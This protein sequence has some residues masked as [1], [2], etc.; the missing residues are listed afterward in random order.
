MVKNSYGSLRGSRVLSRKSSSLEN[1]QTA[2]DLQC[3]TQQ[4]MDAEQSLAELANSLAGTSLYER[5]TELMRLR[6]L[7]AP[8]QASVSA[9]APVPVPVPQTRRAIDPKDS[10]KPFC[11]FLTENPT[12]FHAVDYFEKQLNDAGFTKVPSS[13]PVPFI[14]RAVTD[15]ICFSSSPKGRLG[16]IN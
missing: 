16:M 7:C 1:S 9:P 3:R 13:H 8:N 4:L 6:N 14:S 5:Y 12:I 2:E 11:E 15:F 10:T